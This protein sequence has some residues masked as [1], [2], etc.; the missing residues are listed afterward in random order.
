MINRHIK[1]KFLKQGDK[2][3]LMPNAVLRQFDLTENNQLLFDKSS[4]DVFVLLN[5]KLTGENVYGYIH[6]LKGKGYPI[7]IPDFTLC[8]LNF[9]YFMK[10]EAV[11]RKK[12]LI[13]KISDGLLNDDYKEELFNFYGYSSSYIIHLFA[14]LESFVN[15]L[16]KEFMNCQMKNKKIQYEE[17]LKKMPTFDKLNTVVKKYYG[18]YYLSPRT[19]FTNSLYNLRSLRNDIV[20]IKYGCTFYNPSSIVRRLIDFDYETTYN[21]VVDMMNFYQSDYVEPCDCGANH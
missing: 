18:K 3:V 6:K 4:S 12:D 15:S 7:P 20:H 9:A 2:L 11:K 5:E 10:N 19:K 8:N 21:A 1:K 14:S 16:I 13:N 17:I